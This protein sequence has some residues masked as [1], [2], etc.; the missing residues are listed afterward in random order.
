[1]RG[2][3]GVPWPF[4]AGAARLAMKARALGVGLRRASSAPADTW[5]WAGSGGLSE[6]AVVG[7]EIG[8]DE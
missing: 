5:I 6:K 3:R 7:A 8:R 4:R 1:M 2:L